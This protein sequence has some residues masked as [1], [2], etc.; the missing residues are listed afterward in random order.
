MSLDLSKLRHEG[1]VLRAP[2]LQFS[3]LPPLPFTTNCTGSTNR[4]HV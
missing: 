1:A 3:A 4:V 2:D